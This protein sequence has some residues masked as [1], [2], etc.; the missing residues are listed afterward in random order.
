MR[1]FRVGEMDVYPSDDPPPR[2]DP[3]RE[4][5]DALP[6]AERHVIERTYFGQEHLTAAGAEIGLSPDQ[7]KTVRDRALEVLRARL[8]EED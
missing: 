3:L 8:Q 5:V 4:L 7:A 1:Y 6:K 2:D